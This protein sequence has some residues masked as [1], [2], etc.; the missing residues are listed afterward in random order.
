MIKDLSQLT[1][2]QFIDLVCGDI[3]VLEDPH[4]LKSEIELTVTIRNIL[5]EYKEIADP[6]G[7][8][9][10][11][12][13]GEEMLKVRM[14]MAL[15][16]MC[17]ELVDLNEHDC[18]REV[19]IVY[20]INARAM[21]DQ[22]V[23]AEVKSRVERAKN[24]VNELQNEKD[25]GTPTSDDIRKQFDEQTAALMAHFKFQIDT[26]SMRATVYAHLVAR[27]N[28]EIKAKMAAL[29]QK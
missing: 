24:K 27:H 3:S 18:A 8:K 21:N 19:M 7:N 9:Q 11:L 28:R 5:L 14:E 12:T 23:A 6:A 20:G 15:F 10:F 22:R 4:G 26:S 1:I 29:K 25:A 16:S 2:S 13:I 17:S